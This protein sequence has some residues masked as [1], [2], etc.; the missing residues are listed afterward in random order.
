MVDSGEGVSG[1]GVFA[2]RVRGLAGSVGVV[3]GAVLRAVVVLAGAGEDDGV[4]VSGRGFFRGR[5]RFFA[6][7]CSV[8]IGAIGERE[9]VIMMG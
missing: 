7:V 9:V 8:D 3:F 2:F 5:P 6:I 4:P 1:A